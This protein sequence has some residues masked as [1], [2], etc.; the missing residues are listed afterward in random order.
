MV[1]RVQDIGVLAL[2]SHRERHGSA[3]PEDIDAKLAAHVA[4]EAAKRTGAKFIGIVLSSYELPGIDTGTH[5]SLDEVVGELTD[6]LKRAV[7]T[8]G[9]RA[10]VVVNGHG[11]NNP[12]GGRIP[13]LE[14]EVGIPLRFNS[15]IIELEGPHAGTGEASMA[16]AIGIADE[17][18]L[19]EHCDPD[20]YPEVGF[21][22]L[23]EARE[24]YGWAE[25][26][27]REVESKGVEIDRRMG[28]RM[29]EDAVR[30]VVRDVEHL[31][32]GD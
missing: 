29:V 30:S 9:L 12:V 16:A 6:V 19:K 8:L 32:K 21:V 28:T 1:L 11:G 2:G 27:A 7:L 5:N 14:R 15:R 23:R 17:K 10:A 31:K 3:L 20:R 24:R 25:K 22:G 18:K 26:Q 4:L 13:E